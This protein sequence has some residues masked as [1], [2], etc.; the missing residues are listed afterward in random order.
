MHFVFIYRLNKIDSKSYGIE[1][2]LANCIATFL[3]SFQLLPYNCGIKVHNQIVLN[4][5]SMVWNLIYSSLKDKQVL[6]H[7][8]SLSAEIKLWLVIIAHIK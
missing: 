6:S 1:S 4:T 2:E 3:K 8:P 7:T 5:V